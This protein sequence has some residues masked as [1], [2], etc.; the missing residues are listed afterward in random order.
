MYV[1]FGK[2]SIQDCLLF[3]VEKRPTLLKKN[4]CE[5]RC[6][7]EREREKKNEPIT[8]TYVLTRNRTSNIE[9]HKTSLNQ[10]SYIGQGEANTFNHLLEML[11][12]IK[13]M[14][15]KLPSNSKFQQPSEYKTALAFL[16]IQS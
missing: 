6:L 8:W 1:I 2:V 15:S 11:V 13:K 16:I 10:L 4:T 5:G 3:G 14:T 9:V 12:K 7:F